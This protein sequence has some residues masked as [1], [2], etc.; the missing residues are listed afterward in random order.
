VYIPLANEREYESSFQGIISISP[1]VAFTANG[2]PI[3]RVRIIFHELWENWER[4]NNNEPY[5]YPE[6]QAFEPDKRGNPGGK[7]LIGTS[8]GAIPQPKYR[9]DLLG[10]HDL[11]ETAPTKS[12]I[13][14]EIETTKIA[15]CGPVDRIRKD[16]KPTESFPEGEIQRIKQNATFTYMIP[17]KYEN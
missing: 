10:A 9:T 17:S 5:G 12:N 16:R 4:T 8:N 13:K 2:A 3:P 1:N 6:Q 14:D 7:F 15:P 11:A